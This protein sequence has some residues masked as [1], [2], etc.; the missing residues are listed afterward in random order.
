MNR[1]LI[2]ILFVAMRQVSDD[3]IQVGALK[4]CISEGDRKKRAINK[5]PKVLGPSIGASKVVTRRTSLVSP[6]QPKECRSQQ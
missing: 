6:S 1:A 5:R 4:R 2:F 3:L